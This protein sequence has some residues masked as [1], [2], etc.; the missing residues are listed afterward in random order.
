M[1][2]ETRPA[3]ASELELARNIRRLRKERGWSLSELARR[4][5]M[6]KSI[7]SLIENGRRHPSTKTLD[8]IAAAFEVEVGDLFPKARRRSSRE[9]KLVER[10]RYSFASVIRE[11]A[12]TWREL[13]EAE[14]LEFDERIARIST[15]IELAGALREPLTLEEYTRLPTGVQEEIDEARA[16]LT[17]AARAGLEQSEKSLE[18]YGQHHEAADARE[19]IRHLTEKISA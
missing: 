17:E 9:A 4:T 2:R 8:A 19:R 13:V 18:E 1:H 6:T 11:V 5:N 7:M 16:A 10:P 12:G 15:M 3:V 14:E